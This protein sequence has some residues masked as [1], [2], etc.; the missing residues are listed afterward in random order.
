MHKIKMLT[1]RDAGDYD[2][3]ALWYDV[4]D[5]KH[6]WCRWRFRVFENLVRGLRIATN[7][8]CR[9]LDVGCGNGLVRRQIERAT[10]WTVDGADVNQEG[11]AHNYPGRGETYCYDISE[12]RLEFKDQYDIVLLFDVIEHIEDPH[13]FIDAALFHLK[14]G[15]WL[16]IS[17]P[18]L[19]WLRG[20]YD[21]ASGH[22]RRYTEASLREELTGL[23]VNVAV[24]RH[25]GLMLVPLVLGRKLLLSGRHD[26]PTVIRRGM[27]PPCR[28]FNQAMTVLMRIETRFLKNPPIGTSLILAAMK[29]N[30]T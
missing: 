16:F 3:P 30:D 4:A 11:L 27:A 1:N 18:A 6:F 19:E 28:L 17:V 7:E 9:V 14:P 29:Q 23:D 26:E 10:A 22:L 5:E 25:W 12:R 20:R 15:G 24:L 13:T 21:E 2:F 8:H